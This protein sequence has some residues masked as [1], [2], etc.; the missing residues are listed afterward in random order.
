MKKTLIEICRWH[1]VVVLIAYSWLIGGF[2]RYLDAKLKYM[3]PQLP[4]APE[5]ILGFGFWITWFMAAVWFCVACILSFWLASERK[6]S[7]WIAI[8]LLFGG[9]SF[10]HYFLYST[11]ERQVLS[12]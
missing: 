10:F 9:V 5:D 2:Q 11:L 3:P 8:A 4:A 1:P 6:T 7:Y 12:G